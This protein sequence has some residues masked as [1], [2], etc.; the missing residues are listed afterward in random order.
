MKKIVI[1]FAPRPALPRRTG[2]LAGG[3]GALLVVAAGS[4]WLVAAPLVEASHMA[5]ATPRRL[6]SL[7]EAQA[8]DAAV[9]EL[10]LPWPALLNGLSTE[11]GKTQDV[12]LLRVDTDVQ[13]GSLRLHGE[14]R[15]AEAVQALPARLRALPVIADATLIGSEPRPTVAWPVHFILELRLREPS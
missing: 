3:V 8:V 7:E 4:A 2:W 10:N 14:A 13:H 1:D 5:E 15:T 6:P 11:F 9:R 12:V